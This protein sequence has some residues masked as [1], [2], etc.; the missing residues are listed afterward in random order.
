MLVGDFLDL[1]RIGDAGARD[2]VATTITRP[3]HRELFAELMAHEAPWPTVERMLGFTLTAARRAKRS[4]VVWRSRPAWRNRERSGARAEGKARGLLV[5]A[6]VGLLIG[7]VDEDA[8]EFAGLGHRARDIGREGFVVGLVDLV[9]G[10]LV[11]A[12]DEDAAESAGL[13][14]YAGGRRR[15]GL[16]V[17][18]VKAVM[19]FFVGAV[20]DGAAERAG[21]RLLRAGSL[22]RVPQVVGVPHAPILSIAQRI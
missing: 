7:G 11:G 9:V 20:D 2:P 19:R 13:G 22:E 14:H 21:V 16:V 15:D 12:V 1:L 3:E 10:V 5:T 8:A 4:A 17:G 6:V 18:L